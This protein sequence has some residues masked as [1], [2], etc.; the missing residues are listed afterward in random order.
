MTLKTYIKT[1]SRPSDGL[2]RVGLIYPSRQS[3]IDRKSMEQHT[4]PA[5]LDRYDTNSPN[6]R[7]GYC[8]RSSFSP[9]LQPLQSRHNLIYPGIVYPMRL[10]EPVSGLGHIFWNRFESL[11]VLFNRGLWEWERIQAVDRWEI[12]ICV[13]WENTEIEWEIKSKKRVRNQIRI[14][15]NKLD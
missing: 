7:R 10:K 1:S 12:R 5:I 15:L 8:P 11:I 13:E 3:R 4:V 2:F 14:C 6:E 9:Y